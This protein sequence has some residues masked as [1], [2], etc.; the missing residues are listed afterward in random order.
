MMDVSSAYPDTSHQR[1]LHNLRKMRTD[2]EVVG[3]VASFL[4]NCQTIIKTNEH[5]TPKLFVDFGFP[6]GSRL[7]FILYLI[8]NGDL[9]YDCA[10]KGVD[11]QGYIDDIT[12]IAMGK[13]VKGNNRKLAKVHNQVCESWRIKYG[14]EFSLPKHQLIHIS[15]KRNID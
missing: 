1:L 9:L 5:T 3:W 8:Y 2:V 7:L 6:Q 15:R 13:S 11:T 12:L 4:T 14:S 10:K